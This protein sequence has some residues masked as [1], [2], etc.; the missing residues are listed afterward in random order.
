MPFFKSFADES[1][2]GDVYRHEPRIWKHFGEFSR[3]LMRGPSPLSPGERELIAGFVSGL[4]ACEFCHGAHTAAAVAFGFPDDLMPQLLD[5]I[6]TASV[7]DKLKPILKY[8]KK[9]TLTSARMVQADA[10]AVFAA[11]WDETALHHAIGVAARYNLVNRLI[12][13]HGIQANPDT[14]KER[15]EHIAGKKHG[16]WKSD[17]SVLA[18]KR[19]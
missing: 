12:H 4:N 15:G 13:G 1:E 11:G 8:V 16:D 18:S 5:N 17:Q 14:F 3:E 10:D 2:I 19:D 9:L 7:D 6:D